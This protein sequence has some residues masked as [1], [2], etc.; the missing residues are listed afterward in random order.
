MSE[1][2]PCPR[3]EILVFEVARQRF[4]VLS[5]DV[6]EL[7]R[8]VTVVPLPKAPAIVEGIIDVRGTIVPVLDIR[9]R[10]RL[11]GKAAEH[12]DHLLVARAGE[13]L[14][15]LR[16]D[17]ALDLGPGRRGRDRRGG[18]DR[19]RRRIRGRCGEA[20]RRARPHP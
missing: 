10:F 13:R 1:P 7:L 3:L 9:S 8:T 18:G 5:A 14:V 20:C 11:P 2:R 17:R 12:S 19:A 6:R 15:A 16:V 4:G